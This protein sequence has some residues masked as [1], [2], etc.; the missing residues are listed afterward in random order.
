MKR[1]GAGVT[2]RRGDLLPDVALPLISGGAAEPLR[3]TFGRATVLLVLHA[4]FCPSC[5]H[6]LDQLGPLSGEFL[7]WEGRLLIVTPDGT[8][9]YRTPAF[10]LQVRDLGSRLTTPGAACFVVADRYGQVW[11]VA[12]AGSSHAFPK[13]R[14]ISEWLKY[15]GTLCPE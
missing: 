5:Q 4:P 10:G 8:P 11:A 12:S 9:S 3:P 6:Y 14:E 13:P 7:L 2:I 15:L 1:R